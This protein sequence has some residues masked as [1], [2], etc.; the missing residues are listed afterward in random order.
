MYV[1]VSVVIVFVV[2]Q[3]I[4]FLVRA[5]KRGKELGITKEKLN[6]IMVSSAVFTI[7]PAFAILI[8][9]IALSQSLGFPFPWLRLSVIG[10]ITY[11]T[12][13]AEAA[14]AAFG[15]TLK[16]AALITDAKAFSG[17][18]W[19]MTL[20]IITGLV[21]MPILG[22]KVES[23][24]VKLKAKD[25]HWNE[26]FMA[27]LFLGMISAFL[28]V[29]FVDVSA[30]LTGWIPVFVMLASAVLMM[31]CALLMKITK[32]RW[33]TD[34]ALPVSMLGGMALSI[35]ITNLVHSMV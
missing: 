33:I 24:L 5:L 34:Y 2:A 8:G 4:F 27:S 12:A 29:V 7:A 25:K 28:G 18:A 32:A 6:R 31:L 21:W 3:S 23:G 11:E 17:I 26:I 15:H 30:G 20:G 14:A 16:S 19:V 1:L 9:V 22:K 10:A 13:A 35:P